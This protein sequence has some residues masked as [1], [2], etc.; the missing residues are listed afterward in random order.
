METC[1][2]LAEHVHLVLVCLEL[3]PCIFRLV[4]IELHLLAYDIRCYDTTAL[5]K[6][7]NNKWYVW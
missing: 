1:T 7:T 2:D 3:S 5:G 4:P 6:F